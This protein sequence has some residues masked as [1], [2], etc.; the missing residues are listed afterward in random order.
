VTPWLTVRLLK[1]LAVVAL[2]GGGAAVLSRPE[3]AARLGLA[4][5]LV[6]PAFLATW[7]VGYG[8]LKFTHRGMGEPWVVGAMVASVVGLHAVLLAAHRPSPRAVT[9]AL[10]VASGAATVAMMVLRPMSATVVP[11][12]LGPAL[13]SGLVAFAAWRP[14]AFTH[15]PADDPLAERAIDWVG[16]AEGATFVALL[17]VSVVRWIPGVALPHEVPAYLGWTHGA[18]V[19]VYLQALVAGGRALGW[20]GKV[21][22]VGVLAAFVPL[23][24]VAFEWWRSRR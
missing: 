16:R 3:R 8:L 11:V 23:G 7:L 10:A 14:P 6:T 20:S 1:M 22:A 5:G 4:Y 18:L 24:P 15:D 21:G 17:I 9:A 19:L 13:V 2:A 12:A